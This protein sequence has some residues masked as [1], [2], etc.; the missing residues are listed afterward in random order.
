VTAFRF[1][2]VDQAP[3]SVSQS[4]GYIRYAE[5]VQA[6]REHADQFLVLHTEPIQPKD[7]QDRKEAERDAQRR[8]GNKVGMVKSRKGAFSGGK[9]ETRVVP[10]AEPDTF[11]VLV[12]YLGVDDSPA[13]APKAAQNGASEASTEGST[14]G[15]TEASTEAAGSV[16]GAEADTSLQP[17][18]A[19]A[20]PRPRGR[21]NG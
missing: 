18:T 10:G 13:P 6:M 2:P 19:E 12:R 4:R 21:R 5:Q 20:A 9:W 16:E 7:G 11:D 3:E 1:V 15:S 8:A 14:E 17:E